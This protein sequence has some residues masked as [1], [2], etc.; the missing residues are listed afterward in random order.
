MTLPHLKVKRRREKISLAGVLKMLLAPLSLLL[1]KT[2]KL[3][4]LQKKLWLICCQMCCRGKK[5]L[6]KMRELWSRWGVKLRLLN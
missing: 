2:K 3:H 5:L 6:N 4:T 1:S